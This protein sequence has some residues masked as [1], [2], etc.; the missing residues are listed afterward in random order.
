MP[1]HEKTKTE[2]TVVYKASVASGELHPPIGFHMSCDRKVEGAA[3]KDSNW[4]G[5]A[6]LFQ[7][8]E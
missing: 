4:E 8:L 3:C 5:P 6:L 1:L 2:G 7:T